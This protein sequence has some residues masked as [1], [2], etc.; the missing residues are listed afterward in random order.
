M[1]KEDLLIIK[2]PLGEMKYFYL[3]DDTNIPVVLKSTLHPTKKSYKVNDKEYMSTYIGY[4]ESKMMQKEKLFS[5]T[6]D[7]IIGL[8]G[9]NIIIAGLPKKTF[10]SLDMMHFVPKIFRENYLRS[11]NKP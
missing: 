5:Q 1:F 4:D 10:T 8:F 6:Y 2:T 9:S 3:F 11:V 7:T